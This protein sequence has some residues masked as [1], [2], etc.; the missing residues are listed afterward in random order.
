MRDS[1][2]G[3]KTIR[4]FNPCFRGTCSWCPS[5]A[6]ASEFS[7]RFNPCFRGTCSWWIIVFSWLSKCHQGFNPCFRGTCSWC[8]FAVRE[9]CH[10]RQF[11]SLFS[12]NLLLMAIVALGLASFERFNPCFRGT[13]SW[14]VEID[15]PGG[16]SMRS[17]NPCFRG[18]CSW[19]V[20]GRYDRV[21]LRWCFNSVFVELALDDHAGLELIEANVSFNP[22][23]RGTCSWWI[24]HQAERFFC[25]LF[26]SLF[27]WNLLLMLRWRHTYNCPGSVSILVFV[28][29]ALDAGRI[30][31]ISLYPL[32]RFNPCFRGTCSWWLQSSLILCG[33]SLFQSLFSWNLLLMPMRTS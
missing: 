19:W 21:L 24:E 7:L 18:T 31:G 8:I 5:T 3:G 9:C 16:K 27:S 20:P 15:L 32:G 6:L 33:S 2:F 28:E 14:W 29:L 13:C 22:C 25:P 30:S 23:F 10:H 26:Q 1:K 4:C 11:Q 12:W 17:F